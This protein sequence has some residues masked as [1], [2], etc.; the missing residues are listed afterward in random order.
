MADD[1]Y[2]FPGEPPSNDAPQMR[3]L[4]VDADLA[5]RSVPVRPVAQ[6][7]RREGAGGRK[8]GEQVRHLKGADQAM[9]EDDWWG[10]RH[11]S[12][13][14]PGGVELGGAALAYSTVSVN[15]CEPSS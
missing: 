6:Q 8:V 2:R 3:Y 13:T 15:V 12:F 10:S 4:R 9:H 1:V 5:R 11:V 7:I 14:I